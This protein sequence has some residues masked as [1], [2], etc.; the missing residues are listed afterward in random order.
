VQERLRA[1]LRAAPVL[2]GLAALLAVV[3]LASRAGAGH[4]TLTGPSIPTAFF[5]TVYTLGILL[6]LV[7]VVVSIALFAVRR[8]QWRNP[9][10]PW[11][12]FVL[13]LLVVQA[14]LLG[15]LGVIALLVVLKHA[16]LQLHP[17][18]A[19]GQTSS[20]GHLPHPAAARHAHPVQFSWI[21]A[22]VCG[23]LAV[24]AIA[25][26]YLLAR[27]RKTVGALPEAE[28]SS[29]SS[30]TPSTRRST[31]CAARPTRDGP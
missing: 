14:A 29:P 17:A 25:S 27:R 18:P 16:K 7:C 10:E 22:V 21:V 26:W 3:A 8:P 13:R 12:R 15:V 24:A 31:T 11:W 5:D 28:S 4:D 23:V 1:A 9:Q 20:P 30:P 19:G 2:T 6:L